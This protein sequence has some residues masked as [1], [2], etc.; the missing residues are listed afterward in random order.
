MAL[1][2]L[3]CRQTGPTASLQKLSD[4]GG[5]PLW[6]H[7]TGAHWW[8]LAYP[9][10]FS[11]SSS[12]ISGHDD[13]RCRRRR[14]RN[15]STTSGAC[16]PISSTACRATSSAAAGRRSWSCRTTRHRIRCRPRLTLRHWRPTPRS[17]SSRGASRR[18]SRRVRSTACARS[19]N[20]TF[21]CAAQLSSRRR[22]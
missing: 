22:R 15:I 14:S 3:R 21:R 9:S 16:S 10:V 5:L 2:D 11:S 20:R 18:N 17:P 8:R 13:P 19:S 1:S 4:G 7:P 12:R 6:I